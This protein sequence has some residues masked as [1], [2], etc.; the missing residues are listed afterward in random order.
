MISCY[1]RLELLRAL[2]NE[3]LDELEARL[4]IHVLR[5]YVLVMCALV[6]AKV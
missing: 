2:A 5:V 1:G 3:F 4:V 6:I